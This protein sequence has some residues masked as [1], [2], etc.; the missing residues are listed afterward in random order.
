MIK[1]LKQSKP[2][3][4]RIALTQLTK[5]PE[6]QRSMTSSVR[7]T[8]KRPKGNDVAARALAQAE[9][10]GATRSEKI[11]LIAA[12]IVESNLRHLK[13]GDRDSVGFLQQ[14][15]SMGWGSRNDSIEKDTKDFLKAYRK[16]KGRNIG[17]RVQNTQKS[18]YPDKYGK[19]IGKAKRIVNKKS[20][21]TTT[22]VET[23]GK[24]TTSG[25]GKVAVAQIL[26]ERSGAPGKKGSLLQS[27]LDAKANEAPTST[28]TARVS[29]AKNR[30]SGSDPWK[31]ALA[32]GATVSSAVRPG[33]ITS[34]GNVSDHTGKPGSGTMARD[35]VGKNLKKIALAIARALGIKNYKPGSIVNIEKGG[36][37]YQLIYGTG[38]HKDHVHLGRKPV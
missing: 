19:V 1:P 30:A 32:A 31:A 14:R 5:I 22:T 8:T 9:K 27:L 16:A 33:A 37:R 11:A 24:T 7:T 15:P 36:Y 28:H 26:L 17:E 23:P 20:G 29:Q 12:G 13:H 25:D 18:A 10:M 6:A 21:S 38:D 4:A 3:L 35:F 34:A 2:Q